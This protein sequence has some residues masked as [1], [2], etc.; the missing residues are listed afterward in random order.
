MNITIRQ[1]QDS[2]L[3]KERIADLCDKVVTSEIKEKESELQIEFVDEKTM[4]E[5]NSRFRNVDSATD[6]ISLPVF[7]NKEEIHSDPSNLILLGNIFVCE[8]YIMKNNPHRESAEDRLKL[9]IVHGVLHCL[10][11]THDSDEE[12]DKMNEM[13]K[14]YLPERKDSK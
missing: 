10:G 3:T 1:P 9:A 4:K 14:I 2:M 5:L 11:Y 12:E 13:Q 8:E 6:V 7:N